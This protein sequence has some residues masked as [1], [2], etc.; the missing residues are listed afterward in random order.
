[1]KASIQPATLSELPN[2]EASY[3]VVGENGQT[4]TTTTA[5]NDVRSYAPRF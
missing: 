5:T 3:R 2:Y 4:T 1:M